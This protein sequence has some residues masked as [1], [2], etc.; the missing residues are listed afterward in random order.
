MSPNCRQIEHLLETFI[1]G[2]LALE[3]TLEVEGH[4]DGCER[5]GEQ[6]ALLGALRGGARRS[7]MTMVMNKP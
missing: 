7:Y 1:D 2:E 4:L 3:Q 6:V 5:C